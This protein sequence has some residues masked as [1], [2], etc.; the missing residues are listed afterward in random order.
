MI[1]LMS[2]D[3]LQDFQPK[4]KEDLLQCSIESFA[5]NFIDNL[6]VLCLPLNNCPDMNGAIAFCKLI[7]KDVKQIQVYEE[8]TLINVYCKQDHKWVAKSLPRYQKIQ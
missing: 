3:D 5:Y 2:G 8:D 4:F 7:N 6:A 1:E